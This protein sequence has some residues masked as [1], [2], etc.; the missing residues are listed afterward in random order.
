[1]GSND[2]CRRIRIS[3]LVLVT[4]LLFTSCTNTAPSAT[5]TPPPIFTPNPTKTSYSTATYAELETNTQT[6]T[7]E[8]TATSIPPTETPRP[9]ATPYY[10]A[11]TPVRPV[12]SAIPLYH[13]WG[14]PIA[15]DPAA[16]GHNGYDYGFNRCDN[17][18]FPIY[19]IESGK[20]MQLGGKGDIWID[21]GFVQFKDG[22]IFRVMSRY[23]H[24]QY[25]EGQGF[26][27]GQAVEK[28]MHIGDS[29]PC[30]VSGYSP[31]LELQLIK[32]DPTGTRY[33]DSHDLFGY[34]L[35]HNYVDGEFTNFDPALIGLP[36]E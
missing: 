27:L 11:L 20:I 24:I 1:M 7:I 22:Q 30:G 9:T 31:E 14:I 25:L 3:T 18:T 34:V 6:A 35:D 10:R 21:H 19:A 15:G 17:N 2:L 23:G 13:G 29:L 16:N 36:P 28:G 32:T 33:I 8:P 26:Y 5:A 12:D 4:T